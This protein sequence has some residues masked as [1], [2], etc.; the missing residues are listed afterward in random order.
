LGGL[1]K[2]VVA[3]GATGHQR[4]EKED[5]KRDKLQIGLDW[6]GKENNQGARGPDRRK[7]LPGNHKNK[8]TPHMTAANREKRETRSRRL[9]RAGCA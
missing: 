9:M 6:E 3:K 7:A 2:R 1:G 8:Y 5:K 4:H